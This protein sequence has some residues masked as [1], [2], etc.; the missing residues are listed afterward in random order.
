MEGNTQVVIVGAGLAGCSAAIEAARAGAS[1]L[2]LEKEARLGGNS[3]KATSGI[4]GV[5]TPAQT[6]QEVGD[7]YENLKTD[8]LNS[9]GGLS[10]PLLVET[11]ASKST[12]AV[13]FLESFGVRLQALSQ[14]G[15]HSFPRTHRIPPGDD[16]RP[17]PVG[18]VTMKTLTDHIEK[19]EGESITVEKQATVTRL[20]LEE[21]DG[22]PAVV[23]LEYTKEGCDTPI[24]VKADAVILASGGYGFDKSEGSLLAEFAPDKLSF[25]TTNGPHAKGEGVRL[26]RDV[27]ADLVDMDKVQIHPTGLV[28]P[29]DPCN[30][31]KFLAPEAMRGCGGILLNSQGQRFCNELGRRD[32]VTE[33][34]LTHCSPFP[35]QEQTA[36]DAMEEKED[37]EKVGPVSAYLVMNEAVAKDFGAA[38]LGFYQKM[39]LVQKFE[40]ASELANF[41]GC[42]EENITEALSTYTAAANGTASDPYSKTVFPVKD[43]TPSEVLYVAAVTP[44]IHYCMGGLRINS[45]AE[46]QCQ[47]PS[48]EYRSIPGL[49]GAGEVTGG[50]HGSNRLAGNSLLECVV[51]GRIAGQRGARAKLDPDQQPLAPGSYTSLKLRNKQLVKDTFLFEFELPSPRQSLSVSQDQQISIRT[52][53]GG[54]KVQS[55]LIKPKISSPLKVGLIE[56]EVSLSD[57]EQTALLKYLAEEMPAGAFV[58]F[59]GPVDDEGGRG[60]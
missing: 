13:N 57:M 32:F 46:V 54:G 58:E 53:T 26:G 38:V 36:S 21:Q 39:T 5:R 28:K 3:A 8:T 37:L 52:E 30:P 18:F 51:F 1:V 22:Q 49:F 7:S 42:P 35:N 48:G 19:N 9:G 45:A 40:K 31:V 59:S 33:Q 14:C 44:C 43:F 12:E 4:N 24:E 6:T 2:L 34:I 41:I 47:G 60:H 16:G 55:C 23:G 29:S 11:L 17:V 20:L 27:G 10:N 50:V 15:G 56:F 25:A